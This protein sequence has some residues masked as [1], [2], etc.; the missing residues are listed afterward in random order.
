MS[1]CGESVRRNSIMGPEPVSSRPTDVSS[2][3]PASVRWLPIQRRT[4][5]ESIAPTNFPL[6]SY[7][8]R[9]EKSSRAIV[10]AASET[11]VSGEAIVTSF[12]RPRADQ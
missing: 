10:V 8:G 4:E 11:F 6:W 7:T 9:H 2:M 3:M 1:R 5:S 12:R